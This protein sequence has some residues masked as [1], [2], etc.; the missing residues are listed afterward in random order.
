MRRLG[1]RP[2]SCFSIN[3]VVGIVPLKPNNFT[4]T[5]ERENMRRD[6]I[7]KPPIVRDDHCTPREIKKRILKSTKRIDIEIIR[8]LIE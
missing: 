2:E 5:L 7:E 8:G 3:F 6:S 1:R 4:I